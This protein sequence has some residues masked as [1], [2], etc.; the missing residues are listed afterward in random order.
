MHQC[1]VPDDCSMCFERSMMYTPMPL[2]TH[3]EIRYGAVIHTGVAVMNV[4]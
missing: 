2:R 1:P 4:P 3:E